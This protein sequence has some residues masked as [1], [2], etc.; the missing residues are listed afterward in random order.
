MSLRRHRSPEVR[1]HAAVADS[2]TDTGGH[3]AEVLTLDQIE[4]VEVGSHRAPGATWIQ[5]VP[6]DIA[7]TAARSHDASKLAVLQEINR[8]SQRARRRASRTP[9]RPPIA[10][11]P[12]WRRHDWPPVRR[13]HLSPRQ[14]SCREPHVTRRCMSALPLRRGQACR[15][16]DTSAIAGCACLLQTSKGALS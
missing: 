4:V 13:Q 8:F 10:A 5:G 15:C 1:Q 16:F 2:R 11:A 3:E 14:R 7:E 9:A 6:S 12:F